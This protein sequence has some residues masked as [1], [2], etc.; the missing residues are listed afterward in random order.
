[1]K[2]SLLLFLISFN[3][4]SLDCG[5]IPEGTEVRIDKGEGSLAKA[6]IQDQDGL[7]SCY[8]N[9][10]SLL[11]QSV[12]PGN[13]NISYLNLGLFYTQEKSLPD[14]RKK[15]NKFYTNERKNTDN[16][17]VNEGTSAIWSGTSCATI[18][19]IKEKQKTENFGGICK[20]EDV[21]L[22]HG[23]FDPK[24]GNNLDAS[25][26]QGDTITSASKYMN[27]YQHKFGFAYDKKENGK[28][29]DF[30]DKRKKADEFREALISFVNKSS[31]EFLTKKCTKPNPEKI[32]NILDS[33]MSKAFLNSKDCYDN[34]M[35][36][37]TD[38][39]VCK[40]FDKLGFVYGRSDSVDK[41]M[42]VEF[43]LND[44]TKKKMSSSVNNLFLEGS[45]FEGFTKNL[46]SVFSSMDTTKGPADQKT[47]FA[48]LITENIS[49][50]DKVALEK[51]YNRVAL[52]QIDDCKAENVTEYF[53]DKDEFVKAALRDSVLCKYGDL[54]QRASDFA[55]VI[56]PKTFSNMSDFLSFLTDKAGLDYDRGLLELIAKD[57]TPAKRIKIPES[58]K[59][60]HELM[61][62]TPA[63]FPGDNGVSD[64]AQTVIRNN[65]TKLFSHIQANRGI[66]IDICTKFWKDQTYDYHKEDTSTKDQT[67]QSSGEHGF[68]AITMIGYRCMNNRIQYLSQNSWGPNWDTTVG[69]YEV[70]HGKIWMDEDKVFKNLQGFDYITP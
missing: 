23:F 65:R 38:K 29:S 47:K 31:D 11:L 41:T 64:K 34:R 48:K 22:E 42:K 43:S 14:S 36:I 18:A 53:K 54:L 1:M 66:G 49:P 59:C 69:S 4:W 57:C 21:N 9:Q 5:G 44:D 61:S 26:K 35:R 52:K 37:K 8:A 56:P 55:G 33:T 19:F 70:E 7:G 24:T 17:T 2:T 68:H 46:E 20:A 62:F 51:E 50:E 15:G 25:Q 3:A 6:A 63:D 10:A 67:C 27:A 60:E 32:S 13:P 28:T 12:L 39:P 16:S 58:I 45:G 30:I 40:T